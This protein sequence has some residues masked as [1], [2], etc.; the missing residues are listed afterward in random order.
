VRDILVPFSAEDA[1]V[2]ATLTEQLELGAAD[3]S[4]KE[5]I[6]AMYQTL[7]DAARA[8]Q[9]KLAGGADFASLMDEYSCSPAL[10][11]EPLRSQGFYITPNSFVNS[12]EYVEGSMMLEQPGQVSAPL[13]SPY[14]LHLVQ[15]IGDVTPGE[16]PLAEVSDAVAAE[17]LKQ[18][19]NE[20]Y[21][22]QR[23]A[24]L[25]AAQVKYYPE[26]LR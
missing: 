5:Q 20:Y 7:D 26:R 25:E 24:L 18:K 16:V 3:D 4:V 15:Y 23:D 17:A 1:A 8:V 2:V 13:R 21:E 11:A 9:E 10:K 14:G 12:Q 6:D 22:Q 19:Q